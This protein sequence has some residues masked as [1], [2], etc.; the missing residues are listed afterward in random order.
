MTIYSLHPSR[1]K[2]Q[3]LAT[4]RGVDG[5]TSSTVTSITEAGVAAPIVDALNRISAFATVP[6]SVYDRRGG[7]FRHY[8]TKHLDALA[9][10][11]KRV[12]LLEGSH[13]LW[14]ELVMMFLDKALAD[15]EK[16]TTGAPP[17]VRTA[18]D[19]E[20]AAE[21]HALRVELA[22]YTENV[23]PPETE[24]RRLWEHED[25][26]VNLEDDLGIL[27][28]DTRESLGKVENGI[29]GGKLQRV[30]NDLRILLQA[31]L[32]CNNEFARL[33]AGDL[34]IFVE[35]DFDERYY[36]TVETPLPPKACRRSWKIEIGR[37]EPD[38]PE[39]EDGSGSYTGNPLLTGV[40]SAPPVAS[41]IVDLLNLVAHQPGQLATWSKTPVGESLSGTN[42][43]V[44]DV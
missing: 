4:Y 15:L 36:L 27:G 32:E 16:A 12:Q 35:P 17:P 42:F 2:V 30:V 28:E 41:E 38:G 5:M 19:V 8:P 25:P 7:E 13:S 6:V 44:T 1:G 21:A 14:Y 18:I 29:I 39:D 34:S 31:Y 10:R 26:L 43:V 37:W 11:D 24:I 33:E 9:D 22:E 20:L 3:I 40:Q 23:S